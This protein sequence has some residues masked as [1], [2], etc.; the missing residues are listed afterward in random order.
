MQHIA[1]SVSPTDIFGSL[2]ESTTG[3]RDVFLCSIDF[4][5]V[6]LAPAPT[7][8]LV[9]FES[10]GNHQNLPDQMALAF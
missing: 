2:T 10:N 7:G 6:G 5:A 9:G 4:S 8:L 1:Y 3:A